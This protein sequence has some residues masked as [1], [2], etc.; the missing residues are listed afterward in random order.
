MDWDEAVV[1]DVVVIRD[2]F[3]GDLALRVEVAHIVDLSGDWCRSVD[4]W[5]CCCCFGVL[6]AEF[7]PDVLLAGRCWGSVSSSLVVVVP[8]RDL[9]PRSS[10]GGSSG[11]TKSV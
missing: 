7:W 6:E 5:F 11:S 4:G 2:G 10:A 1:V 8:S 9:L 3:R